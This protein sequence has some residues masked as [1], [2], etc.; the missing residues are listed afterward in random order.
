MLK[1]LSVFWLYCSV[2]FSPMWVWYLWGLHCVILSNLPSRLQEEMLQK[3][4][5]EHN[6]QSYRQVL[7]VIQFM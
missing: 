6:L 4:E 2:I 3:E 5:A 7:H 1:V